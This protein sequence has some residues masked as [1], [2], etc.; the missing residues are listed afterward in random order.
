MSAPEVTQG[1]PVWGANGLEYEMP[2]QQRNTLTWAEVESLR[3]VKA[4]VDP[5]LDGPDGL[6]AS[7]KR[8]AFAKYLIAHGKLSEAC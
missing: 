7:D 4:R 1:T 8:L 2:G 6:S 3:E 5:V